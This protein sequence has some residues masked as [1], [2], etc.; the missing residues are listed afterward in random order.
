MLGAGLPILCSPLAVK[1]QESSPISSLYP[2][3]TSV[4]LSNNALNFLLA[5]YR[6]IFK[7]A[8]VK[9]LA[10]AVILTAGLAVGQ[11]Q[12]TPSTNPIYTTADDSNWTI[13]S[14]SAITASGSRV[15]GDYDNG[16]DKDHNDGIVSGESL[17]IGAS[18]SSING[19]VASITSGSA[20]GGYVMITS[21]ASGAA[22]NAEASNNKL[23]VTSGGVITTTG[24]L[25]GGWAK[26]QGTGTALASGNTLTIEQVESLSSGGQFIGGMAGGYH[27]AVAES[28]QLKITGINNND[29]ILTL[30]NTAGN[31]GAIVYVGDGDSGA[32]AGTYKAEGNTVEASNFI[33]SGST[34]DSRSFVGGYVTVTDIEA[35]H[36]I[37]RLSSIGNSVDL[38]NFTLGAESQ[39]AIGHIV[40]NKVVF[41]GSVTGT[42]QNIEA[43]GSADTGVTLTNGTIYAS[44]VYGGW[45]E[46]QSG[47]S[48]S[49]N[50]NTINIIDTD[51]KATTAGSGSNVIGG[52]AQ[53][54]IA[55]DTSTSKSQVV[56]LNASNNTVKF[57]NTATGDSVAAK[58]AVG[59]IYGAM[60]TL[61]GSSVNNALGSTLTTDNNTVV[62]G[63]NVAV[64]SGSIH[65]AYIQTKAL[66][67]GGAT[68]HASNNKVTLDGDFT[69][70]DAAHTIIAVQTES[71]LVTAEGN[72]VVINGKVT[73]SNGTQIMAVNVS[74]QQVIATNLPATKIVHNLSNNSV[75]IG[76]GAEVIDT[77]IAAATS[78]ANNAHTLNNDVTIEGKVSNSSIYG[79]TGADSVVDVKASA[80]LDFTAGTSLA[81]Q[82]D[83]SI[84]SDVVNLAGIVNVGQHDTVTVRGFFTDGNNTNNKFNTNQTTIAGTA[85]L[86]NRGKINLL[87]QTTVETGA[88]LHAS[89]VC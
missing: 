56:E 61:S 41:G 8:Y 65:G 43:N 81:P 17:V 16:T 25:V 80:R 50:A 47:G 83:N 4:K 42:V 62:V 24:N 7:R 49:A 63:D 88:Q 51:L 32:V 26:T 2:R 84:N 75:T 87:G 70:S 53:T 14:G 73:G 12:A 6:A 1:A 15:A 38:S 19:D 85:Q 37:D 3:F 67:S 45:A 40:G 69:A 31:I 39:T 18:D 27:G 11:A 64:S 35:D 60:V 74:Q 46:S 68:V 48:A 58:S 66:N 21:G 34:T 55:T 54:D 78:N 44:Q 20:Y 89:G 72:S 71:G 36:T 29:K 33:A 23:T 22:L 86:Y 10:S 5:Q 79:G 82:D 59:N 9:G 30:N 13:E 52:L 28:N 77:T 76:A 57:E